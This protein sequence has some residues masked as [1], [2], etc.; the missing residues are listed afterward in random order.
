MSTDVPSP[1]DLRNPDVAR[2][3]EAGALER[4]PS[5]P[6]FFAAFLEELRAM[7]LRPAR[8]LE[9]GSGPGFLAH[10]LLAG[11]PDLRMV[12]LDFSSAMHDLARERLG[13]LQTRVDF[14][15]R[16]FRLPDWADDLGTFDAVVTMQAVHE[17]RH[18]RHA[19]NLYTQVGTVLRPGGIFL[20]CDHYAG[21]ADGMRD[22]E[23][24]LSLD[25]HR[26]ALEGAGYEVSRTLT[27]QSLV[28]HRTQRPGQGRGRSG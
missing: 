26:A 16:S 27:R 17:L 9:L 25:E 7:P 24:Y 20:V 14:V 10:G 13:A 4:R 21:G 3:W 8:V 12:L 2:E 28:L 15:E 1:I 18:K 11:M 19:A 6:E 5:R 22:A 23:L